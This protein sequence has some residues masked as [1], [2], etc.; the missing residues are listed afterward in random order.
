MKN[1][2]KH[3][4]F[5]DLISMCSLDK[6]N[7]V[8]NYTLNNFK[9]EGDIFEIGTFAGAITQSLAL[10]SLDFNPNIYTVDKFIWD[11]DKKKKFT[12][13]NFEVDDDFFPY[14]NNKLSHLKNIK[15]FKCN[16]TKIK[17]ERKIE[18]M[19]IDAPKRMKYVIE[20]IKIFS[21]FWIENRTK[22]L[23]EDYNQ[24]L[25]YELPATLFPITKKFKFSSDTSGIVLAE[26]LNNK[27]NNSDYSKMD[28]RKWNAEEIVSNWNEIIEVG[29]N[30]NFL[31]KD[32]SIFMHLFDN[33]FMSDAISF[34]K[35][36]SINFEKYKHKN[37]FNERYLNKL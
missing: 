16:F 12:N 19:F 20:L 18:L 28:I 7:F 2:E 21:S 5:S 25:S 30:K 31:E 6:I 36:R 15:I 9:N 34:S 8:Y 3:S 23:F 32:I 14:V 17:P 27:I 29:D 26:V 35:E 10:G 24:F 33:G 1:I 22:L 37:K 11:N 4:K 13:L